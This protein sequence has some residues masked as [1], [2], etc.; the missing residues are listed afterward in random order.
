MKTLG[1]NCYQRRRTT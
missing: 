1:I